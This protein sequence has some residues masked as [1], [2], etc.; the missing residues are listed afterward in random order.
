MTTAFKGKNLVLV[1]SVIA[2]GLALFFTAKLAS[3]ESYMSNQDLTAGWYETEDALPYVGMQK[4]ETMAQKASAGRNAN[5][6]GDLDKY[7]WY[8]TEDALPYVGMQNSKAMAQKVPA[9]RQANTV[10]DLDK[11]SWYDTEDALPKS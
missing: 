11:Y 7:S 3:A 10:D 5:T 2:W 1:I 8:E 9:D 4:S 6:V